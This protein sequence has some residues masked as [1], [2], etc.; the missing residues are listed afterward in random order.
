MVVSL[1]GGGLVSVGVVLIA[2]LR[3]GAAREPKPL[4]ARSEMIESLVAVVLVCLIALG[5][6]LVV[7]SVSGGWIGPLLGLAVIVVGCIAAIMLAP[8]RA[9]TARKRAP[10]KAA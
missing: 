4:W 6:S 2:A 9:E 10:A 8:S 7:S 3:G 1:A 5:F